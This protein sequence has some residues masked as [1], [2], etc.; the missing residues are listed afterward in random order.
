MKTTIGE[1]RQL[2]REILKEIS[3]GSMAA[4]RLTGPGSGGS[5]IFD[6]EQLDKISTSSLGDPEELSPHLREPVEDEEDCWG[7][8][9]PV[10]DPVGSITDPFSQDYH[11]IPTPN[12]KR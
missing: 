10:A 4:S 7:P 12:I 5:R 2:I 11:V 9:P 6:R 3:A 1:I 8:V